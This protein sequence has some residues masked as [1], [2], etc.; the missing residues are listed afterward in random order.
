MNIL[1]NSIDQLL[2]EIY[3][4]YEIMPVEK[5]NELL[6]Y[7][8]KE[9]KLISYIDYSSR[10]LTIYHQG[11]VLSVQLDG[12]VEDREIVANGPV[13]LRDSN[14]ELIGEITY[15]NGLRH[16]KGWQ[17]DIITRYEKNFV[18]DELHGCTSSYMV[19]DNS[20]YDW[21]WY[22]NGISIKEQVCEILGIPL[23]QDSL[24]ESEITFVR[25]TL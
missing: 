11:Y 23:S 5:H 1:D 8:S 2:E 24:T 3:G 7:C 25:C 22:K 20:M 17:I 6:M 15:K 14:N 19:C 12:S 18:E 10:I 21:D 13:Y 16:G 4:H 9:N